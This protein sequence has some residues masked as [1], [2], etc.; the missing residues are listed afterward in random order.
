MGIEKLELL[1][2]Y[3]CV[4][5]QIEATKVYANPLVLMPDAFLIELKDKDQ[6]NVQ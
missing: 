5:L 3:N 1:N 2:K 4:C 6:G